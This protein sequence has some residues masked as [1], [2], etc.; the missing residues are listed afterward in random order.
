MERLKGESWAWF[1]AAL[2][3]LAPRTKAAYL[4]AFM[5]FLTWGG[6]DTESLYQEQKANDKDE[7]PRAIKHIPLRVVEYQKHLMS[8]GKSSMTATTVA[9]AV[10]KFFEVNE[11]PFK[12]TIS[13]IEVVTEEIC[14]IS[15]DQLKRVLNASGNYKVKAFILFAKDSGLRLGD[16]TKLPVKKL[17]AAIE[18]DHEY[19]T[20]EWKTQKTGRT[21]NPVIGPEALD[22]LRTW[23]EHRVNVL[24]LPAEGALFCTERGRKGF[25]R[26][27]VEVKATVR[28]DYMVD[29]NMGVLF[30]RLVK[31]ASL[32]PDIDGKLPSIH[33]CRKYHKTGLESGGCPTSWVNRMQGRKGEGTGGTYTKPDAQQLIAIYRKAYSKLE[34]YG[35]DTSKE[36]TH[37]QAIEVEL[38]KMGIRGDDLDSIMSRVRAAPSRKA[39]YAI[40]AKVSENRTKS[41]WYLT[42]KTRSPVKN[43]Y[44]YAIVKSEKDL[45]ERLNSG[46]GWEHDKDTENGTV[47]IRRK[48]V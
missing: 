37:A 7:D 20:F 30:T 33:S 12:I 19:Y 25:T 11:L 32:E 6:W 28:G 27:G 1:E 22:A 2:D 21:A 10:K 42:G 13:K 47:I 24:K 3:G 43:D 46:E 35:K 31:K 14:N 16:I 36:E 18:G 17:R 48:R 4:P 38:W 29:S 44:E 45:I 39:K 23:M 26:G 5:G 15:K 34:I 40:L 9:K 41:K 8:Q